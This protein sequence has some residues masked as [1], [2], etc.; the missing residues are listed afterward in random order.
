M[1]DDIVS[2]I[3]LTLI[4]YPSCRDDKHVASVSVPQLPLSLYVMAQCQMKLHQPVMSLAQTLVYIEVARRDFG[5]DFAVDQL[6]LKLI[7]PKIL[8]YIRRELV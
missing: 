3:G 6:L 1:D 8:M 4:V 7:K 2:L 5:E